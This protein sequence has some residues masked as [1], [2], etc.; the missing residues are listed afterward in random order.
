M[1][2]PGVSSHEAV[3]EDLVAWELNVSFLSTRTEFHLTQE[4]R[5]EKD[6]G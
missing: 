6:V 3:Q 1:H 2:R 5:G 4:G